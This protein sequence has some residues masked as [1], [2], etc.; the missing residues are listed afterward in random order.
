MNSIFG[1]LSSQSGIAAALLPAVLIFAFVKIREHYAD[2]PD[3]KSLSSEQKILLM[4]K[5]LPPASSAAVIS[6]LGTDKFYKCLESAGSL[7]SGSLKLRK[8][9]LCDFCESYEK[10]KKD[11][12]LEADLE[13]T[14]S[15]KPFNSI[16]DEF[17]SR[18]QELAADMLAIWPLAV[19]AP[20]AEASEPAEAAESAEISG[21]SESAPKETSA[22]NNQ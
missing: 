10:M 11:L 19:S 20:S 13:I 2:I 8:H 21:A 22:E 16:A 4:I 7:S 14:D 9:L 18:E 15:D 6:A 3:Y 1:D 12:N 17:K 5:F